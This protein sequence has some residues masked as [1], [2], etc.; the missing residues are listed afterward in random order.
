MINVTKAILRGC[1]GV[2]TTILGTFSVSFRYLNT[3]I[4]IPKYNS[5]YRDVSTSNG[6]PLHSDG[7]HPLRGF[8][9][10]EYNGEK[11]EKTL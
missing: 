8:L 1:S 10:G 11:D 3:M 9:L 5:P 2:F 6:S 7:S 4:I